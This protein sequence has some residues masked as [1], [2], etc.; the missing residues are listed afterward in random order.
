MAYA[1]FRVL[2]G[3][4]ISGL[5]RGIFQATCKEAL[6]TYSTLLWFCLFVCFNGDVAGSLSRELNSA[7][8]VNAMHMLSIS[9]LD[10]KVVIESL[11]NLLSVL[12][13]QHFPKVSF[14]RTGAMLSS[15]AHL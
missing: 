9:S 12:Q 2:V 5:S 13:L 14:L 15:V 7:Q 6:L 1:G 10:Q 8:L 3:Q 4:N 11:R